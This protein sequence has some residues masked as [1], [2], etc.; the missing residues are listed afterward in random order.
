VDRST[1]LV[2]IASYRDPELGRTIED[3]LEK[4]RFPD[5]L[6][7]GV[8]WQR[9]A[10][11]GPPEIF[12]DERVHVIDVDWR[13]SRGACWARA[14]I[15]K[16]WQGEDW[17]LQLDS[18]H[19]FVQDWDELLLDQAVRTASERPVL[20]TYGPPYAPDEP[21]PPPSGPLRIEFDRFSEDGIAM[22]RPGHIADWRQRD[23]PI[24]ARFVSAH[25]LFAPGRFARDVPYDPELYFTG[26]EITLAVRAFTSGYDL[27]HPSCLIA[28][29]EYTRAYRRKHWDDH[30]EANAIDVPWHAR[31]GSS[32]ARI[33]RLLTEPW[34]GR[35]GCG[36]ARTLA[37]YEAYAGISFRHLRVQ[38]D[39]RHHL[40]PPNPPADPGWARQ[41]AIDRDVRIVLRSQSLPADALDITFWYVGFHDGAG[42]ELY[43]EDA[44]PHE[45]GR[46]P[47]IVLT[48]RFESIAPPMSWTVIPYTRRDGWLERISGP[49]GVERAGAASV[50]GPS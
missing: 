13:H 41:G 20:T 46:G 45:L 2:S 34:V 35:F 1:I 44:L 47:T 33:R 38:D 15:M 25:L 24:P 50:V 27:F 28:W 12:D 31:D 43:R 40:D 36:T 18:H 30:L 22:F 32:R 29:H 7:F 11:E 9:G 21:A 23:R 17:Y 48:R 39:T 16:L 42:E 19:R 37:D 8:C 10:D 5:R 6:R 3:C 4:A 14:E 26:E 49:V